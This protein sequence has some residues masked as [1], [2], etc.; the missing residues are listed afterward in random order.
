MTRRETRQDG[1]VATTA[2]DLRQRVGAKIEQRRVEQ[3]LKNRQLADAVGIDV[4]LLQKHKAGDNMP[5]DENLLRY[6]RALEVPV[7]WFFEER[8]GSKAAVA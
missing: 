5:S 7:S 2:A 8:N 6:A 1:A 4:R 3:G